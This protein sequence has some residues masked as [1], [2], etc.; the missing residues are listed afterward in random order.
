MVAQKKRESKMGV[1]IN[2]LLKTDIEKMSV[3]WLDTMLLKTNEL[4]SF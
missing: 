1:S 3:L 4:Q 2:K